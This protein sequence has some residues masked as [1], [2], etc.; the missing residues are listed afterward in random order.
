MSER[1]VLKVTAPASCGCCPFSFSEHYVD[2]GEA[3]ACWAKSDG[4]SIDIDIV[5]NDESPTWCPLNDGGV[6]EVRRG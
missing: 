3:Y 6:V 5:D 2:V 4:G 1:K